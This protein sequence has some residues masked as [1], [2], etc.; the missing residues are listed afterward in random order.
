MFN[1]LR[2]L[3]HIGV[4]IAGI[5][6]AVPVMAAS[7]AP[8]V[9]K[10]QVYNGLTLDQFKGVLTAANAS[11]TDLGQGFFRIK[12]GPVVQLTQCPTDANGVCY[13]VQISRTF[14]NVKPTLD[15]VNKWNYNY[16]VPRASIDDGGRLHLDFWVSAV[17]ITPPLLVDSIS[18]FEGA[19]QDDQAQQF[20]QPFVVSGPST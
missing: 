1:K 20:W 7:T 19:W 14:S 5:G 15:A 18:W 4:A 9:T 16:K 12:D 10:A 3:L 2:S 17:G 13:E 11:L 6:I 8:D